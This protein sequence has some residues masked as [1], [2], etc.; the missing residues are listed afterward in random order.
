MP[1]LHWL[2]LLCALQCD[3]NVIAHTT[4]PRVEAQ[5]EQRPIEL[6]VGY[7]F[8][9]RERSSAERCRFFILADSSIV[10]PVVRKGNT[11]SYV[12]QSGKQEVV[13]NCDGH[14]VMTP[15]D[16]DLFDGGS[17]VLGVLTKLSR[18]NSDWSPEFPI[19]ADRHGQ[20]IGGYMEGR[21]ALREEWLRL[22]NPVRMHA[23]TGYVI[24]FQ[25][26][27]G[28]HVGTQCYFIEFR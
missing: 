26:T 24:L 3:G 17:I 12:A 27:K 14:F 2:L 4:R 19:P 20:L 6:Q 11:F 21:F 9:D 13:F 7:Y 25:P 10:Q 8:N 15:L 28:R 16:L 23:K 18:L 5:V 22:P 1:F